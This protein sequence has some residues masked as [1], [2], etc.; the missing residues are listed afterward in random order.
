MNLMNE[1]IFII[2]DSIEDGFEAK[3][4][5]FSIYTEADTMDELKSKIIEAVDCHF[6]E[7]KPKLIRLHYIKEEI[8]AA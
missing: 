2:Q 6:D 7:N 1:I 5:G 4:V 3:A 8:I